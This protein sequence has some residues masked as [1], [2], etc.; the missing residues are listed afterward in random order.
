MAEKLPRK[1]MY[2]VEKFLPPRCPKC[3]HVFGKEERYSANLSPEGEVTMGKKEEGDYSLLLG[4]IIDGKKTIRQTT[5]YN[6]IICAHC[7]NYTARYPLEDYQL[8]SKEE[9]EKLVAEQGF[10]NLMECIAVGN[11]TR[12]QHCKT[13]TAP[14]IQIRDA[15]KND[16]QHPNA[17][18]YGDTN[19]VTYK[20]DDCGL[21]LL[22]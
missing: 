13:A 7:R 18:Y 10:Q 5:G 8:S 2:R 12:D 17:Y 19:P 6:I 22:K 1:T 15:M 20:C 16:C 9:A 21:L 3:D 4:D 14:D 11:M